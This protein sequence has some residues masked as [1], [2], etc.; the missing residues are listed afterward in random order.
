MRQCPPCKG[1]G[2]LWELYPQ[3]CILCRGEGLIADPEPGQ[4]VCHWCGGNGRKGGLYPV[5]CNWCGGRG[6]RRAQL[7][8]DPQEAGPFVFFVQAGKPRTAHLT[9]LSVLS[10]LQGE[11]RICDPYYGTGTLLRLDPIADKSVRFLT[12]Q[13]D[14]NEQSRGILSPALAEFVKQHPDVEFKRH[15]TKDLHDRFI[16]CPTELILLGHGLKDIGNKDS[17]VVRLN[18]DIAANTIEEVIESFDRKWAIA[19]K[20]T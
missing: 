2:K 14:S 12:Q 16:V 15:P 9:M 7:E 11:L 10:S 5:L 17:F 19:S 4:V 1:T 3:P 8:G 18:R 20:L 6:Y 13:P